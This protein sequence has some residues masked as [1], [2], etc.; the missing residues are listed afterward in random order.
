M[1]QAGV[2]AHHERGVGDER[3][4]LAERQ[5]AAQQIPSG[6]AGACGDVQDQRVLGGGAGDDDPPA[7]GAQ[8]PYDGGVP[9]GRPAPGGGLGAWVDDDGA[10]DGVAGG[11]S[12]TSSGSAVMA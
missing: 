8:P 7:E 11:G 3:R 12:R 9:F 10:G 2:A 1:R 6:Q 4:Q 5:P